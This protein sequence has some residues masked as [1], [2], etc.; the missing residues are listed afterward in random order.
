MLPHC[1]C[2]VSRMHDGPHT[3]FRV[4]RMKLVNTMIAKPGDS[5]AKTKA[6]L[7]NLPTS[8]PKIHLNVS[9]PP[10]QS[11]KWEFSNIFPHQ[12]FLIIPCLSHPTHRCFMNVTTRTILGDL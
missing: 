2:A 3:I 6:R 10:P 8:T 12:Y 4:L 7:P 11:S 9:F 1:C 5:I